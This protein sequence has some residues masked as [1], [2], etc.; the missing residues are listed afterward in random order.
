MNWDNIIFRLCY[1]A[2]YQSSASLS[3]RIVCAY[4]RNT[5]CA[6]NFHILHVT[7]D[8]KIHLRNQENPSNVTRPSSLRLWGVG[9]GNETI[10]HLVMQHLGSVVLTPPW[11][12]WEPPCCN[13]APPVVQG[14]LQHPTSP[15]HQNMG[16]NATPY[17]KQCMF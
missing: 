2:G 1:E 15:L 13:P 3:A 6:C 9:S 17:F 7:P 16:C 11:C 4:T 12:K 14:V 8:V 10:V 5:Y